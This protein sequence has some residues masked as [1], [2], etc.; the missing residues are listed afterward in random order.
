MCQSYVSR[1][2]LK[3]KVSYRKILSGETLCFLEKRL[4]SLFKFC[5]FSKLLFSYEL[6]IGPLPI[7]LE[8]I[9]IYLWSDRSTLSTVA[10]VTVLAL[11]ICC[12]WLFVLSKKQCTNNWPN[13]LCCQ[14]WLL[15]LS[16]SQGQWKRISSPKTKR[17]LPA[18]KWL[19]NAQKHVTGPLD[20]MMLFFCSTAPQIHCSS[21]GSRAR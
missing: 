5:A 6:L 15:K 9:V 20:L 21:H 18:I 2:L 17:L 7:F 3:C 11:Y 12:W 8:C 13:R 4:L 10:P 1:A 16:P 19:Q 14:C